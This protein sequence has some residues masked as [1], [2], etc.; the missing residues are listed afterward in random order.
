MRLPGNSISQ[1]Y[2]T[3][4]YA[5]GLFLASGQAE[6]PGGLLVTSSN[7][8]SWSSHRFGSNAVGVIRDILHVDGVFYL[9]DNGTGKIWR[10]DRMLPASRPQFTGITH[11]NGQTDLSFSAEPGFHYR[12]ECTDHLN[13]PQWAPCGD[14]LFGSSRNLTA[15]DPQADVPAR[16]YRLRTD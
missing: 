15:T 12:L 4:R 2:Y 14:R 5:N 1:T 3:A 8:T 7:G 9:A 11:A 10:S 16:F 13:S 6:T